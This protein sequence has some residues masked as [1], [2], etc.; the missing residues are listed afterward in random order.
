MRGSGFRTG[1]KCVFEIQNEGFTFSE[2]NIV[3]A[4]LVNSNLVV[5]KMPNFSLVGSATLL[6]KASLS[7][8]LRLI[9]QSGA[10]LKIVDRAPKG[11]Y[12]QGGSSVMECPPGSYCPGKGYE[13][14]ILC[15]IGTYSDQTRANKCKPCNKNI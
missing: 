15:P 5:C 14:A 10:K 7:N 4:Q 6:V 9:S 8:N 2:S 3:D 12:F 13:S 11:Y 1:T